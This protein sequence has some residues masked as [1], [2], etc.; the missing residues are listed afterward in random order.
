[1]AK[2]G[3]FNPVLNSNDTLLPWIQ[4]IEVHAGVDYAR[5]LLRYMVNAMDLKDGKVFVEKA[6]AYLLTS[7]LQGEIMTLAQYFREQGL[8]QGMEQ[9]RVEGERNL[10]L[11]QLKLK[12]GTIPE[13]YQQQLADAG[14]QMLQIWSEFIVEATRLEDVFK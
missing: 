13:I 9:G 8:E 7:D 5:I 6:N 10:I 1:M 4:K 2:Y 14:P 11:R 3:R 12:F